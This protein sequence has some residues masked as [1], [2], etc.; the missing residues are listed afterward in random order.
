MSGTEV[1]YLQKVLALD[2]KIYPEGRVSGYFGPLTEAAVK[3]FQ[4][5][6]GIRTTG[7]VGPLTRTKLNELYG[8]KPVTHVQNIYTF[9]KTLKKGMRGEEVFYLQKVL[10]WDPQIYP[11]GEQTS[12]FGELTEAAVKRF[13]KKYGIRTTGQV[14]PQT[15]AKLNEIY[16]QR[17]AEEDEGLEPYEASLKVEGDVFNNTPF[18]WHEGTVEIIICDAQHNYLA[19]GKTPIKD[20]PAGKAISFVTQWYRRSFPSDA[21]VCEKV[22]NINILDQD[23]AFIS[24]P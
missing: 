24:S 22:V 21:T 14:G 18:S 9:T 16:A 6:Y 8:R 15:R 17:M 19:V 11:E 4:K 3:R 10:H 12:Y 2:P 20:I 7:E 13:Q 1:R 23:N 5:K